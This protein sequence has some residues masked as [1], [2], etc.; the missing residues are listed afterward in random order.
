MAP[1]PCDSFAALTAPFYADDYRLTNC[2]DYGP[3]RCLG[4]RWM[5]CFTRPADDPAHV[6]QVRRGFGESFPLACSAALT[7]PPYYSGLSPQ[8]PAES[9][10][11]SVDLL[12]LLGIKPAPTEPAGLPVITRRI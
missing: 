10:K 5:V 8:E 3:D 11:S 7:S 4:G 6:W 2:T 9:M 12:N 1:D